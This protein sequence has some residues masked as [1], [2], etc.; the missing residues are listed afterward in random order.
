MTPCG[1]AQRSRPPA[2]PPSH[3]NPR[4]R[5]P[6]LSQVGIVETVQ[7]QERKS[8]A[9]AWS[10]R[11]QERVLELPFVEVLARYPPDEVPFH[12]IIFYK[13]CGAKVW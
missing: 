4:T 5:V 7:Q 1:T 13:Q 10:M 8:G 3:T 12:R 2:P 9:E 6:P 11:V